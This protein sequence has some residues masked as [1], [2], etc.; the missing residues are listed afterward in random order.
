[1][2]R[3]L[4]HRV[5]TVE[6]GDF[7]PLNKSVK[8]TDVIVGGLALGLGGGALMKKALL[9]ID[10]TMK[11]SNPTGGLP[12]FV[13]ANSFAV[14]ALLAS[15]LGALVG[16]K[17]KNVPLVGQYI[18]GSH[19]EGAYVGGVLVGGAMLAKSLLAPKFPAFADVDVVRLGMYAGYGGTLMDDGV[20]LSSY[21]LLQ[22]DDGGMGQLAAAS[23]EPDYDGIAELAAMP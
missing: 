19:S 5:D 8:S 9:Y 7:N 23:M 11:K 22:Q 13:L 14:G 10:A 2:K 17:A 4:K 18:G 1:M 16:D 6:L 3:S 21:G 20:P 12:A 15:A